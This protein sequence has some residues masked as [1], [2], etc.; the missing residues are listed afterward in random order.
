MRLHSC[1]AD[2]AS[3]QIALAAAGFDPGPADGSFG[4][5]TYA[6][7]VA[8]AEA[9]GLGFLPDGRTVPQEV[10]AIIA[11]DHADG[12]SMPTRVPVG[13]H[14]GTASRDAFKSPEKW[15]EMA[16]LCGFDSV[17]ITL[18]PMF[19]HWP[20]G[21]LLR[22]WRPFAAV[23]Q[24]LTL[25]QSIRRRGM[26]VDLMVYPHPGDLGPLERYLTECLDMV[27]PQRLVVDL[28]ENWQGKGVSWRK[29]GDALRLAVERAAR[30]CP[31]EVAVTGIPYHSTT[32]LGPV[33]EWADIVQPQAMSTDKVGPDLNNDGL[34]DW[35]SPKPVRAQKLARKR[36]ASYL[37]AARLGMVLAAYGQD[38]TP[39]G[40]LRACLDAAQD[41]GA[42]DIS[43][44]D[45]RAAWG[46][47]QTFATLLGGTP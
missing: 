15:A 21:K 18:N 40:E 33:I 6:A 9:N 36:W 11:Q 8:W 24:V 38:A 41:V 16:R 43:Y 35:S 20:D 46:L 13:V 34:P 22:K 25:A 12:D 45:L 30:S 47:H 19:V 37:P 42:E 26:V 2:V 14:T 17:V 1:G 39:L 27:R 4:P 44:W 29:A 3:L 10:L 28:E 31:V 23:Q 7:V 32:R 5:R